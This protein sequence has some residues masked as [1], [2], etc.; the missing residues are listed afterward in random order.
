[1]PSLTRYYCNAA[2]MRPGR[3]DPPA[4]H[5]PTSAGAV[6]KRPGQPNPI[7]GATGCSCGLDK[8]SPLYHHVARH[9]AEVASAR[10]LDGF[11]KNPSVP[12]GAGFRFILAL[13][14]S[15]CARRRRRFDRVI[16]C[17]V[18]PCTPHA[19]RLIRFGRIYPPLADLSASGGFI[20]L[21]RIYPPP[22]DLSASG[23]RA[24]AVCLGD[25][26]EGRQSRGNPRHG[27]PGTSL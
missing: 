21:R 18:G 26:L 7:L 23:G 19:S 9:I 14:N 8:T 25:F 16:H 2:T 22:E 20:R 24:C 5:R 15:R 6:G 10:N 11:V 12:R 1:M 27:T 4:P 17:G 13:L 3:G